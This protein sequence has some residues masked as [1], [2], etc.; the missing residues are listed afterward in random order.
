MSTQ[1]HH[2][3]NLTQSC[4]SHTKAPPHYAHIPHK[5]AHHPTKTTTKVQLNSSTHTNVVFLKN[6][7]C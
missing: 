4:S 3:L 7:H 6:K 1:I 2:T 5:R